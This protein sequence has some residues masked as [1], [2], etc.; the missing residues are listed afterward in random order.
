[1]SGQDTSV[2]G[3]SHGS[4][5]GESDYRALADFR[6]VLRRFLAFSD[7]AA[8]TA[9]LTA[10]RYQALLAIRVRASTQIMSVG[11]LAE[12]LLIK[13]HSAAELVNRLEAAGL[14]RRAIDSAD[15]RRVLLALTEEGETRL[16]QLAR[17]QLQ[18]LESHRAALLDLMDALQKSSKRSD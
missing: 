12:E 15:R 10:Q 9:G 2:K 11:A 18:E 3:L 4:E 8:T 5:P 7:A 13:P 16:S 6:S 14:V 17:A 1:M